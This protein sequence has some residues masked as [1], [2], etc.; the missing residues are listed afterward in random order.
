MD[1]VP[2]PIGEA[3]REKII[4]NERMPYSVKIRIFAGLNMCSFGE[5]TYYY[6]RGV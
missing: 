4:L 1:P 3:R 2:G 5:E 6:K